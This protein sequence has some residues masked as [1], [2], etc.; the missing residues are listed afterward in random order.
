MN[1]MCFI[2]YSVLENIFETTIAYTKDYE[3]QS[4]WFHTFYAYQK[5]NYE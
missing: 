2:T 1:K 5:S 3:L 4:I